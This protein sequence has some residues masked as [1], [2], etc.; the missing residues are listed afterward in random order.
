M[1]DKKYVKESLVVK[2]ELLLPND[3]NTLNNLVGGQLM[4]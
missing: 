1:N 3:T 4:Y 2:S